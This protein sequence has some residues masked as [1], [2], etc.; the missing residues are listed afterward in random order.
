[1]EGHTLA[2]G[3]KVDS[4]A[5]T[6]WI[7]LIEMFQQNAKR[8]KYIFSPLNIHSDS[9]TFTKNGFKRNCCIFIVNAG[10]TEGW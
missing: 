7:R 8:G 3:R 9:K 4:T 1:M 10:H 6:F 2:F 5:E